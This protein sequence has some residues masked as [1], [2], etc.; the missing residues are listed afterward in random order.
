MSSLFDGR[1]EAVVAAV[2]L[3]L[4]LLSLHTV[5]RQNHPNMHFTLVAWLHLKIG[6]VDVL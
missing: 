6:I 1:I 3:R 2:L 5:T 4:P